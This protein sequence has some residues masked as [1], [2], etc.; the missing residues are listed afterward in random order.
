MVK[1]RPIHTAIEGDTFSIRI[2]RGMLLSFI[3][4]C[5]IG[6]LLHRWVSERVWSNIP[7]PY[8][9]S[10]PYYC[11]YYQVRSERSQ[12]PQLSNL[13]SSI[14]KPETEKLS[15]TVGEADEFAEYEI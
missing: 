3:F 6:Y 9:N 7:E 10:N 12:K 14:T 13:L 8:F 4:G 2:D 1:R 15:N 5:V 11:H